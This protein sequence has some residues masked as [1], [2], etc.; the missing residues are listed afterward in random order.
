MDTLKTVEEVI[1]TLG[2]VKAVQELT[3][4]GSESAVPNW[5]LRKSFPT[6]TYAVLK[7]ALEAK[8]FTAP[9]ELWGM[10]AAQAA[11]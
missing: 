1:S 9:D 6:N 10:E 8:G 3:R 7:A 11:S 4:R 2:G 5:K